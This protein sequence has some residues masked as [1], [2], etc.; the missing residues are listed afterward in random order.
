MPT[1]TLSLEG[2]TVITWDALDKF[3]S[4]MSENHVFFLS[5]S[6]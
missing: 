4:V 6:F 3:V 1:C 5:I 2:F